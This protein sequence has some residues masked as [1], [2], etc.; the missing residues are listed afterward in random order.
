MRRRSA[1]MQLI[2]MGTV[3]LGGCSPD[4]PTDRYVYANHNEC[5]KD[6]GDSNC[7]HSG[8]SHSGGGYG[9]GGYYCYGPR[10]KSSVRLPTGETVWSGSADRLAVHPTTGKVLGLNTAPVSRG[11]FGSFAH[12]MF[13]RGG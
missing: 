11:G 9:G 6:W 2:A 12:S 7:E 3:I 5:V 13:S 8:V 1:N 10:Y 4:I